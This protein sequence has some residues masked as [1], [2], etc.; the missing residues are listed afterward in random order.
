MELTNTSITTAALPTRKP[1]AA[2]KRKGNWEKEAVIR[3]LQL[4]EENKHTIEGKFSGIQ[5]L[6]TQQKKEV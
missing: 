4:I 1:Q 3:F 6:T 2:Y 5:D